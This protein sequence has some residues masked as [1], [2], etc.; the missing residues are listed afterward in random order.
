MT[1]GLGIM[2]EE[3]P[4][5]EDGPVWGFQLWFNLPAKHKITAPRYQDIRPEQVPEA[6][7]ENGKAKV[8]VGNFQ[9]VI[10]PVEGV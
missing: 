4:N 5:Q 7:L 6:E 2:H 3:M 8:L 10:G 9:G 1:A